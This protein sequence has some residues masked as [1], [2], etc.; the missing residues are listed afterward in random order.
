MIGYKEG[1]SPLSLI[2]GLSG[3]FSAF[4][5]HV[6]RASEQFGVDPRDIF[7][8]L[9]RRKVVAGQEDIV[10]DVAMNLAQMKQNDN[11]SYMIES[12]L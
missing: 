1:I 8:E 3:V 11:T 4:S 2:S 10:V 5:V 7:I 6:K 9:G 12:L